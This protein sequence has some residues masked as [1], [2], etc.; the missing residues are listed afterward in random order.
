V[1]GNI[2]KLERASYQNAFVADTPKIAVNDIMSVRETAGHL[3][4]GFE[5]RAS[6]LEPSGTVSS[7]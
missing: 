5:D 4:P 6:T 1:L 3:V 7:H 2:E